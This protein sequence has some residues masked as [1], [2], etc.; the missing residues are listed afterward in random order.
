MLRLLDLRVFERI[1]LLRLLLLKSRYLLF[2]GLCTDVLKWLRLLRFLLLW[3]LRLLWL[4]MHG[5]RILHL[6][7]LLLLLLHGER[8]LHLRLLLLL[9]SERIL[10]M[11]LMHL[12]R[13]LRM[14]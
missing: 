8:I 4:L 2:L 13:I 6:W 5:E 7:V 12:V 10:W 14:L 9:L 1:L 3:L 11:L